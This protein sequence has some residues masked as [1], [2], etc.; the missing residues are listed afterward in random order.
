M[1]SRRS[2]YGIF[3]KVNVEHND[4]V[5]FAQEYFATTRAPLSEPP[6][7]VAKRIMI[8]REFLVNVAQLRKLIERYFLRQSKFSR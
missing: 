2:T 1:R 6:D 3:V 8:N 7:D 5:V 4:N